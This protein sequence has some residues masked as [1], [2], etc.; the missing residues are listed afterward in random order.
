MVGGV[1]LLKNVQLTRHVKYVFDL[2]AFDT[3]KV[4]K[5]RCGG[6]A[7]GKGAGPLRQRKYFRCL[8][9]EHCGT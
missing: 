6:N 3:Q 1:H 9:C 4:I 2:Y 7:L 8:E 5:G